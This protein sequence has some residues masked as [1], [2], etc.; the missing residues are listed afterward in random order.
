[1]DE[2]GEHIATFVL[3]LGGVEVSLDKQLL[4]SIMPVQVALRIAHRCLFEDTVILV[5]DVRHMLKR[6][7]QLLIVLLAEHVVIKGIV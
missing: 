5:A 7:Q 1:L 4:K 3:G 2:A 6:G